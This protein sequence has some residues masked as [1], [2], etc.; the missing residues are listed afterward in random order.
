MKGLSEGIKNFKNQ[1][2][3]INKLAKERYEQC[4]CAFIPNKVARALIP[5]DKSFPEISKKLCSKCFCVLSYKLRQ[6]KSKC[7]NWKR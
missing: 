3:E 4:G 7:K 6:N 1:N 2:E 5:E